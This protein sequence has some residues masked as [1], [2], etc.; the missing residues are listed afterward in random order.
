MEIVG[1][2]PV[3]LQ[4]NH[5]VKKQKKKKLT[6]AQG[7]PRQQ[8]SLVLWPAWLDPCG[9]ESWLLHGHH[10]GLFNRFIESIKPV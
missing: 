6:D 8:P 7:H 2:L 4:N 9:P 1:C 3:F 5:P 10:M